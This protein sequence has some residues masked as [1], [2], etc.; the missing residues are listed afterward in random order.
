MGFFIN[1]PSIIKLQCKSTLL[2]FIPRDMTNF[3]S[4]KS[5]HNEQLHI[6]FF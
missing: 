5:I 4:G 2:E 3:I 1:F 6:N